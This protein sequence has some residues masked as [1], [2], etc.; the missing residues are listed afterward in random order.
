[1]NGKAKKSPLSP[2]DKKTN[3]TRRDDD[4]IVFGERE[5]K[6][7]TF[8]NF[9]APMVQNTGSADGSGNRLTEKIER[10]EEIAFRLN[11][12]KT[13]YR[14]HYREY[15]KSKK[16]HQNRNP[17]GRFVDTGSH[18]PPTETQIRNGEREM[19]GKKKKK[20]KTGNGKLSCRP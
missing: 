11:T 1:L 9:I 6:A 16:L 18:D 8:L 5:K 14:S 19:S 3:R 4:G 10:G 12:E 2:F 7:Y 15:K 13:E 20:A 17:I